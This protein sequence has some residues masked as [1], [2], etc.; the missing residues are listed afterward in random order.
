MSIKVFLF[1]FNIVIIN[2]FNWLIILIKQNFINKIKYN[3]FLKY[4]LKL[5]Y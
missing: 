4:K 5:W 2:F 3:L 1:K